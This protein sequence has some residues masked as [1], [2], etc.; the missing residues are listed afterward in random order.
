MKAV[1]YVLIAI[2]ALIILA[3]AAVAIA[4]AVINPNDYKPQ[5]EQAVEKQTNLDLILEGDIG[6]SFLPLGLELNNVAANLEGERLVAME[7]LVA[8]V[9]FW[10]L[11][12]MSPQVDTF[13]L[14]GL[15]ARLV[16]NEQ[17]V[18][19]WT[20]IMPEP[21]KGGEKQ[22]AGAETAQAPEPAGQPVEQAGGAEPLNFNVENV[23]VSNAEVKYIDKTT[24]QTVT[25][26]DFTLSASDISPGSQFPLNVGFR[27]VTTDPVFEVDG[28]IDAK[29][30]LN[31]AL[32]EFSV[33]GLKAVFDMTG[34]PFGTKTVTAELAGSASANLENE[35]ATLS[36]FSASLANL[37]L[38]TTLN[39]K[40]FGDKPAIDGT[41][42]INEFSLKA[43]MENLG[44][45]P[46]ETR[47]PDVLKALAFS[48]G[49]GGPAGKVELS[50]VNLKL[51]DTT[52]TGSGS[53]TLANGGVV[54]NLQGDKLN[55]DR[56]LP[57]K[58][59]VTA[60]ETV[61]TDAA[62]APTESAAAA[63]PEA[64]LLPLETLRSLL[65]DI[66]F[67]LGQ[68]I[69]SNLSIN[70]IKA[71]TTAK[72][73]LL[74]VDEF[75]GKLYEGSFGA[76][77]TID[78]RT[79]NPKWTVASDVSNVQTLPLLADLAE[80]TMLAGGANLKVNASTTGNRMS[81]LRSNAD[82]K[83]SFNLAEGEFRKLNLTRMA[84]QGIALVNQEELTTTDWGATTPFND[85]RGTFDING[86]ILNNTD[87]VASL[88]GMK[89][90]GEG[91]VDLRQNLLDYEAGLR[92]VGEIHRDNACRVTEY[93]KNAVIPVEC[94]GNFSEEPASLCSFDGS[95][96]RDTLQA[97]AKN[98]ARAKV[99]EKVDEA[100]AKAEEKVKE[101]LQDELGDKLKGL[102]N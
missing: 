91:T 27:V 43:L 35:T 3:V 54:F 84:C 64:D 47:D 29:L 2:V 86:N 79:D 30:G 59:E 21:A 55:A 18:G 11:I 10:S 78:A 36:N 8:Q 56:Y 40:G 66:D 23:Q 101:K 70:E 77:A 102:F 33:A 100:K 39:V 65:L 96:F 71:S 24:G 25:L 74:K 69:V 4:M 57:P 80:V 6:W 62:K 45:P 7:K 22:A 20:R 90:E 49:I 73:G 93:V 50:D 92:I 87:L 48:T 5:I 42:A 26:E 32:N 94:R 51:D 85:M 88:A 68:L 37:T 72:N 15:D 19:N 46:I 97:I 9:D 17:G 41:L 83:V 44:Q 60:A 28:T 58:V 98:A 12:A 34:A 76:N 1:R 81:A 63:A 53:Y 31:E 61:E 16:V 38:N 75:S 95:R 99:E 52:F 13:V 89:L 14:D 67:G 82:G